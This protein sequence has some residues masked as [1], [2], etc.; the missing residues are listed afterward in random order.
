MWNKLRISSSASAVFSYLPAQPAQ[1]CAETQD[2]QTQPSSPPHRPSTTHPPPTTTA[3]RV[4]P[5]A[6]RASSCG[7]YEQHLIGQL[8]EWP[9]PL[10]T[11]EAPRRQHFLAFVFPRD[12]GF[13]RRTPW[14]RCQREVPTLPF[15]C[16]SESAF[17]HCSFRTPAD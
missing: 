14:S 8:S 6:L 11:S 12:N 4:P 17:S 2:S 1:M 5:P 9:E 3:G 15:T 7:S 16:R 13:N 10:M